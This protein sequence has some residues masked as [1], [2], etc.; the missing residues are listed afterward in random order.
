MEVKR[1]HHVN[2]SA[3]SE[4]LRQV[5]DFYVNVCGLR[6]GDTPKIDREL[7]WLYCGDTPIIHLVAPFPNDR[8]MEQPPRDINYLDHF[9]LHCKGLAGALDQ[10]TEMK[11]E[12]NLIVDPGSADIRIITTD[13]VGTIL[14]LLFDGEALPAAYQSRAVSV[15]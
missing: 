5:R 8:R 4:L 9:A 11:K 2:I 12:Y 6:S 1:L 14:E 10:M 15:A 3:P 13:P 7:Y